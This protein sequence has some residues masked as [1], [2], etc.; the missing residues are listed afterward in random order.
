MTVNFVK[1]V[2]DLSTSNHSSAGQP[3]SCHGH[4][5]KCD[6]FLVVG[7]SLVLVLICW[8]LAMVL[9]LCSSSKSVT[10]HSKAV[11]NNGRTKGSFHCKS[12]FLV[13]LKN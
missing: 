1:V 10:F 7:L 2:A 3:K 4:K 6:H 8:S 9:I 5:Q 11:D 12:D 13:I